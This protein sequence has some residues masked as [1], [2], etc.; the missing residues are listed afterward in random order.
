MITD[1]AT[2][3]DTI[4]LTCEFRNKSNILADPSNITL[5]LYTNSTKQFGSTI[6]V[7][8]ANRISL[9]YYEVPY[10]VQ[11]DTERHS[12]NTTFTYEF[13]GL[14]DGLVITSRKEFKAVWVKE[15]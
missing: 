1:K 13:S 9:G 7:T 3:G 12:N 10:L 2:I 15:D 6:Y 14:L 11:S 8:S 4:F 5:K